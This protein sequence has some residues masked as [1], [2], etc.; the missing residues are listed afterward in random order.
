MH[1]SGEVAIEITVDV[2]GL[3]FGPGAPAPE[4][5]QTL[6]RRR[7]QGQLDLAVADPDALTG[8]LDG[9]RPEAVSATGVSHVAGH[10]ENLAYLTLYFPESR[11]AASELMIISELPASAIFIATRWES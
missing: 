6:E 8:H 1:Q 2:G 11:V 7:S 3:E 9:D 4:Q 5:S 10:P